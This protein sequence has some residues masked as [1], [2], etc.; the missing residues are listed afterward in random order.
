MSGAD[1]SAAD[2]DVLVTTGG[3]SVG[4]HDLVGPV[5]KSRGIAL[6]FWKIAMRPGKPML[7]GKLGTQRVLGL[8]GNPVSALICGRVFLMPLIAVLFGVVFLDE[9][10]S[11]NALIGMGLILIG[12]LVVN[13]LGGRA[14][15]VLGGVNAGAGR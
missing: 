8:P 2:A 12:S 15:P 7:F 11:L 1:I 4:D 5:L 14:R 13:G 3:A 9:R 10:L 6:D